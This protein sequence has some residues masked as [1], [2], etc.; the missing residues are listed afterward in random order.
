MADNT[1]K[2][3]VKMTCS[4]CSGA[5][6]RVLKKTEGVSSHTISLDTQTVLVHASIP[7]DDVL[8]RIKKTGKEVLAG[9]VV[10]GEGVGQKAV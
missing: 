9:E 5:V 1:Y 10:E 4:G 2:F 8:A 7:Y 3:N 6:D